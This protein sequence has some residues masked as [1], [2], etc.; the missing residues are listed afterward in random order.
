MV[1][2]RLDA[3]H[4]RTCRAQH[5]RV[6]LQPVALAALLA[7]AANWRGDVE[8]GKSCGPSRNTRVV[9][10]GMA[11]GPGQHG[12]DQSLRSIRTEPGL[13]LP[14]WQAVFDARIQDAVAV[15]LR[16]PPIVSR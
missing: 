13:S 6:V 10:N 1:Q 9:R 2:A 15:P 14:A 5:L 7:M 11:H 4:P 8:C 3:A 16:P 12:L